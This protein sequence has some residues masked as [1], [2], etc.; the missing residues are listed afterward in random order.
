MSV[1]LGNFEYLATGIH[2][3][4]QTNVVANSFSVIQGNEITNLLDLIGAAGESI[5]AYT[6]TQ[7]DDKLALKQNTLNWLTGDSTSKN[8][9]STGEGL[10][11]LAVPRGTFFDK[12][13]VLLGP[14]YTGTV[15]QINT[16]TKC[17]MSL[18]LEVQGAIK[19]GGLSVLTT[20]TGYTKGLTYSATETNALL[21]TLYAYTNTKLALK[22]DITSIYTKHRRMLH[23][24]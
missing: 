11:S 13:M 7:T 6:K 20:G 2:L 19:A 22:S 18:D 5:D 12:A 1:G 9:I 3:S 8:T 15:G 4:N 10:L 23:W 17:V 14:N 21:D 24:T 16:Y